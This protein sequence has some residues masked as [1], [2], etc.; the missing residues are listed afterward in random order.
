[1]NEA[2][3]EGLSVERL[4]HTG[5]VVRNARDTARNYAVLFG[6]TQWKVFHFGPKR[7]EGTLSHGLRVNHSFTCAYGVHAGTGS[8]SS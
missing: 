2:T 1:M 4:Y 3:G 5:V 8:C 7:L 6:V